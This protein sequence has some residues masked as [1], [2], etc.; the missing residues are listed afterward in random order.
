LASC[1]RSQDTKDGE[2]EDDEARAAIEGDDQ[3]VAGVR[4]RG[5]A[6][7]RNQEIHREGA[8]VEQAPDSIADVAAYLER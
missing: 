8:E 7:D 3:R 4:A 2:E 1:H 6:M 5:E